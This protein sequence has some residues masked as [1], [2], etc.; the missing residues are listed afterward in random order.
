VTDTPPGAAQRSYGCTYGCGNPYDFLLVSVADSTTEFLCLPCLVHLAGD[1]VEAMVNPDNPE[2][3]RK[4]REAGIVDM[5]TVTGSAPR[6]RGH[7]APVGTDDDA[8]ISAFD[9][10]VMAEELS[11][12]FR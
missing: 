11:D 10:R 4:V 8:L 1:M 6:A 9:D 12:E 7:N 5:A 3:Q 2:V